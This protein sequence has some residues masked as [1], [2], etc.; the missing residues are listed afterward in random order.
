MKKIKIAIS[1]LLLVAFVTS[2]EKETLTV[3]EN[4]ELKVQ[5]VDFSSAEKIQFNNELGAKGE[6]ASKIAT[7]I[8]YMGELCGGTIEA[9]FESSGNTYSSPELWDYYMFYGNEGDEISIYIPRTSQNM[10]PAFALY[11]GTT[12]N[13]DGRSFPEDGGPDMT[14]LAFADDEVADTFG[15]CWADPLLNTTL[16]Q[17]GTYTIAVLKA[18]DC[19]PGVYSYEIQTTGIIC[20]Y[21]ND[22]ILNEDDPYPNSNMSE[23][24]NIDGCYPDIENIFV[25]SGTTMM[26]QIDNLI[27]EINLQ[28]DGENWDELHQDFTRGLSKITYYWRKDRLITRSER[29]AISSCGWSSQIP[30]YDIPR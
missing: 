7:E 3:Q 2:C 28:Y 23:Y 13:T 1:L 22:G 11:F 4:S 24:I 30:Y 20:D 21:D 19:G 6:T 5:K 14:F 26:D 15:G 18:W 12:N 8:T 10:D 25:E 17:T 9:T 29:S 16:P 27:A